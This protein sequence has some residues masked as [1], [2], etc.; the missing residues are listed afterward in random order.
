MKSII[1]SICVLLPGLFIWSPVLGADDDQANTLKPVDIFELEYADGPR[2]SPD[3]RRVI[4][5]RHSMDIMTDSVRS[6]LWSINIDGSDHR[7]LLSGRAGYFS[8]RWSPDGSRIAY[9]STAEGSPQLY[10]RWL[11]MG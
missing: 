6:N 8:P 7:P 5:E 1:K 3:G 4:Y 10:V 9:I 11:D 2:I